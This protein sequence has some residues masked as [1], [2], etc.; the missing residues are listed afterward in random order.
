VS[1]DW[2]HESSGSL[3]II[4]FIMYYLLHSP[5]VV[6]TLIHFIIP[7][8]IVLWRPTRCVLVL[9]VLL[10]FT[11]CGDGGWSPTS[12]RSEMNRCW[13]GDRSGRS[14]GRSKRVGDEGLA[15]WGSETNWF[16]TP[17]ISFRIYILL[18]IFFSWIQCPLKRRLKIIL[19]VH[20]EVRLLYKKLLIVYIIRHFWYKS[21]M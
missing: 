21:Y 14:P 17:L 1:V 13:R 2:N 3:F 16:L 10:W 15:G 6:K 19:R 5:I 11:H 8:P 9:Q 12:A 4:I 20:S 18:Y 7:I